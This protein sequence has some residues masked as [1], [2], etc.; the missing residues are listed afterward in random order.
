M[1]AALISYSQLIDGTRAILRTI[2]DQP[3]DIYRF[4]DD[5]VIHYLEWE[6]RIAAG[7]FSPDLEE[8]KVEYDS[9]FAH[10]DRVSP[11]RVELMRALV[12]DAARNGVRIRAFLTPFH[13]SLIQHLRETR[14]FDRH[15][16]EVV[17]VLKQLESSSENFTLRDFTETTSFEGDPGDYLDGSHPGDKNSA[18]LLKAL[19]PDGSPQGLRALQ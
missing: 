17:G 4:D 15:R 14:E 6:P 11:A 13:D 3:T 9:R 16:A 2:R 10:W 18:R 7:T 1:I 19:Y 5:G 12:A 8:S